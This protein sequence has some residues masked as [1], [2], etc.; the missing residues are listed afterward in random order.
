M[1]Q[2]SQEKKRLGDKLAKTLVLKNP[3]KPNKTPRIITL[4][5]I[6]MIFM[7]FLILFTGSA[8]KSSDAYKVAVENIEQNQAIIDETGGIKGY[9][10]MPSGSVSI[11]N[12]FGEADLNITVLGNE[13]DTSVRVILTKVPN[14]E[15]E[16]VKLIR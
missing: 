8:M 14:G 13:H 9:G 7:T 2:T 15:W 1:L 6:G 5:V 12:G 10:M 16:L 4:V 3:N 11:T